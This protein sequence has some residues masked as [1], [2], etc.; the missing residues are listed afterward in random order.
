MFGLVAKHKRILQI[1]LGLTILPC[2]FLGLDSYTRSSRG[3]NEAASV[4][5][6]P[7]TMR[8]FSDEMRRQ[9]EQ[10][11]Q[12]LGKNADMSMLD[13]PEMRMAILDSLVSR[14]VITNEVANA[15]LVM[16]KDDVVAAIV[17]APEFQE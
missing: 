10:L 3:A 14:R 4:D 2:A 1:I 6:T 9:Q 8:E 7:V 11:R 16:S 5:G 13:T 12:M 17:A 15:G